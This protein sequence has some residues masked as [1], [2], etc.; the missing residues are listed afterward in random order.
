MTPTSVEVFAEG[1][2]WQSW[3]TQNFTWLYSESPNP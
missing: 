3:V 1:Q 2:M